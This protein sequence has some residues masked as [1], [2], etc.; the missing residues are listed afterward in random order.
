MKIVQITSE[1]AEF[2]EFAY[3]L[4]NSARYCSFTKLTEVYNRVFGKNVNVTNCG[5]CMRQRVLELKKAL[6]DLNKEILQD[7]EN[8][9]AAD[10]SAREVE[11]ESSNSPSVKTPDDK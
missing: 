3:S 8:E 10:L 5:S 1:D 6:D 11:T 9:T 4:I 7:N 2:I